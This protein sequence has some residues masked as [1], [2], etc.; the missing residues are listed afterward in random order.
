MDNVNRKRA[1]M[2][3]SAAQNDTGPK[4]VRDATMA[5]ACVLMSIDD[6]LA[7]L[8]SPTKITFQHTK[9]DPPPTP[10]VDDRWHEVHQTNFEA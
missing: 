2:Y 1:E 7:A 4:S 6:H 5:V 8:A 3:L 10:V 9:Q